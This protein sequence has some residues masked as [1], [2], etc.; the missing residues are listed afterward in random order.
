MLFLLVIASLCLGL[1]HYPSSTLAQE[2]MEWRLPTEDGCSLYVREQG[3]GEHIVVLH[4]GWGAEHSYMVS[5]FTTLFDSSRFVF[6]DQRGSLRSNCTPDSLITVDNHIADLERLR[7]ALGKDSLLLVA[8][9]M[10]TYLAMRYLERYPNRV[11]GLIFIGSVPLNG[12]VDDLTSGIAQPTLDRW[13]RSETIKELAKY[14]LSLERPATPQ[15]RSLWHAITFGSINLKD[16]TKWSMIEGAHYYSARAG[17]RAA[18]SMPTSWDFHTT[19]QNSDVPIL[20]LHGE[21]DYIP[22]AY[23]KRHPLPRNVTLEVLPNT[24]HIAWIDS[25]ETVAQYITTYFG[26]HGK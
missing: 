25:P 26:R 1:F 8:H 11:K 24:G 22:V 2:R 23:H 10:G 7:I 13:K 3:S 12:N 9:S 16:I 19:V 18:E 6:Y 17:Q 21:D 5:A 14:G 20:I 15:Q 4:G